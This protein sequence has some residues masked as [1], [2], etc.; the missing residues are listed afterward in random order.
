MPG[1]SVLGFFRVRGHRSS[2]AHSTG[3]KRNAEALTPV[4]PCASTPPTELSGCD[5]DYIFIGFIRVS[6]GST[7][8]EKQRIDDVESFVLSRT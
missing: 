3:Q 4:P 5:F 6:D 1:H 7:V 2:Q 8:P